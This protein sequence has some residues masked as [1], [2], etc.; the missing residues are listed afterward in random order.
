VLLARGTA[1]RAEMAT[2]VALGASRHQL[3]MQVAAESL[4]LALAG[5][6]LGVLAAYAGLEGRVALP[7]PSL[8]R[9]DEMRVGGS[10][11]GV[12]AAVTVPGGLLFGL[13]AALDAGGGAPAGAVKQGGRGPVGGSAADRRRPVVLIT[14]F[15]LGVV[16]L[17]GAGLM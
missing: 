9:L 7:P 11:L 3:A 5:G 6:T 14:E 4:L 13:A 17:A 10:V 12:T 8:P 1:R 15:A 2:R 16:L